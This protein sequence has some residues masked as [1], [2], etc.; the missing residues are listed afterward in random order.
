MRLGHLQTSDGVQV[1]LASGDLIAPLAVPYSS[2]DE[3]LA[4]G[5]AGIAALRSA[6]PKDSVA[7]PLTGA[8]LASPLLHPSKILCVGMN[9]GEHA[10]EQ[11]VPEPSEPLIFAKMPSAITGPGSTVSWSRDLTTEVDWEVELAVVVGRVLRNAEPV[12]ALDAVFG[13][14]AANDLS[15]RDLQF[16]DGQWTRSKSLDGFLPLGPLLVTADEFGAPSDHEVRTRVNGEEVQCS[17]TSDLIFGVPEILSFLSKSLT[18]LPGDVILTGTPAGVGAFQ[19][20]PRFLA[21]GDV[22]EVEVEGIGTLRNL[23]AE[24]PAAGASA[25]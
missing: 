3:L 2:L 16:S 14:T 7:T 25:S 21:D 1:A 12:E 18:L 24:I 13:Y 11:G 22:V 23:M 17:T 5:Q 15:A 19:T 9:Y 4:D 10:R 8:R 6:R 20:P